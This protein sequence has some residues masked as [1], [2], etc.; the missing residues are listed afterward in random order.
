MRIEIVPEGRG[1]IGRAPVSKPVVGGSSP[2][3]PAA[4]SKTEDFLGEE[5]SGEVRKDSER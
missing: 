1:S 3:G 5:S 4:R 2:S